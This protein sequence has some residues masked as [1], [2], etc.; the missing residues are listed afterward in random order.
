[1]TNEVIIQGNAITGTT[2]ASDLFVRFTAYTRVK[3]TTMKG[4]EVCLR[5]FVEWMRVNGIAQ[6]QREDIIRYANDLDHEISEKTGDTLAAGTRAQYLRAV[7]HFFKWTASEGLYPNISDNIKGAKIKRDNSHKDPLQET[8]VKNV[9]ESID[10][11]SVQGKRNYAI[12]M[13]AITAGL[14][15]CEMQTANISDIKTIAGETVLFIQGKGHDEK[16]DYKKIVPAVADALRDYLSCRENVKKGDPLFTSTSNRAKDQRITEPGFSRLIKNILKNA[17]YDSDRITAHSLRHT[18][19]TMLLKAGASIQEAQAHA[20]HADPATTE[21]Y[22]HNIDKQNSHS[23]QMIY[24]HIFSEDITDQQ[25]A[26]QLIASMSA[27]QAAAI[28][29]FAQTLKGVRA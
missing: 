20:R 5:H 9:T 18:S 14:R 24:D 15:I 6:P 19:V 25:K 21:I 10:R 7:K 13:L 22:A 11:S 1:M 17:G 23:E 16:D 8:D 29:Q 28:L 2:F 26:Q 12:M 27:A 4:Y 3:E